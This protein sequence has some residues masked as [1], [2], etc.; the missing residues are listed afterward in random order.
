MTNQLLA[1]IGEA[2]PKNLD[3]DELVA[4]AVAYLALHEFPRDVQRRM[5]QWINDRLQAD[6]AARRARAST[7]F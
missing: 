4:M 6:E 3:N 2:L 1:Q 7:P 5:L